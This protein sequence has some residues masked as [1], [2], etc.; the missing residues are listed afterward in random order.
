LPS[1]VRDDIFVRVVVMEGVA[2]FVGGHQLHV[3]FGPLWVR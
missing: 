3:P 1:D 2:E